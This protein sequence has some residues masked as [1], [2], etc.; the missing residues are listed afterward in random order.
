MNAATFYEQ[1]YIALRAKI[2]LKAAEMG[3]LQILTGGANAAVYAWLLSGVVSYPA[4]VLVA[5]VPLVLTII[6]GLRHWAMVR[7]V[8]GVS[9]YVRSLETFVL[10]SKGAPQGGPQGWENYYS[11]NRISSL[12]VWRKLYWYGSGV[13][14]VAAIAVVYWLTKDKAATGGAVQLILR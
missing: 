5:F 9:N 8:D 4:A 14:C 1:E 2:E 10:S 11:T 6:T 7:Y 3:R 12:K 13:F